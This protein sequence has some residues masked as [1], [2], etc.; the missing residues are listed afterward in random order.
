VS[1]PWD[2]VAYT[3]RS[4]DGTAS[5]AFSARLVIGPHQLSAQLRAPEITRRIFVIYIGDLH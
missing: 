5:Q 4:G 2:A 3:L 1:W